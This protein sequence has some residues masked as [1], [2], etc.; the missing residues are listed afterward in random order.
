[1]AAVGVSVG[2][3]VR[4]VRTQ[5]NPERPF[6]KFAVTPDATTRLLP[7]WAA[8]ANTSAGDNLFFHPD[9][10]VPAM[11]R[12]GAD[13]EIATLAHPGARLA[14]FDTFHKDPSRADRSGRSPVE[15]RLCASRPA[16]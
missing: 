12:L 4:T 10:A 8:L 6:L 11:R 14:A 7:T 13:V 16:A 3:A 15:P 9:F 2:A 5:R 1:M